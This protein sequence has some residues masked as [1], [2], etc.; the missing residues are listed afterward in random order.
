MYSDKPFR[1]IPF[2]TLYS[3]T[4]L[5]VDA[6]CAFLLLGMLNLGDH[7]ITSMLLYNGFAFV[8]QA[9]FGFIIDKA[10]NPKAAAMLGLAFVAVSF[11]F[12]N[13]IFA[14]LTIAGIGNALFHVAGGSLVLTLKNKIATFSG[15]Y[16]APGGIGLALGSFLS[17]SQ[18]NINFMLFPLALIILGLMLCYVKTPEFNRT[19]EKENT[20]DYR[21]V[22][23]GLIMI[24]IVVRSMIGL[25]I[26]FP[27][28]E[29]HFL[30]LLLIAA[31]AL[32]KVFGG[33][34]AERYGLIKVGV[35]GLLV[36]SPLLAFFSSMPVLGILGAFILNF[37]MPVTLMAIFN[38]L[39][40]NKGLVFGLTTVA[41]FIGALP[42]IIGN[43]L[44]LKQYWV[45][46]LLI[47][48]AAMILFA[49][50]CFKPV[51]Y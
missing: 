25:S 11:L 47:S 7:I 2:I 27:W 50:L 41:L 35:G 43:D 51:N 13:N 16:V 23:V 18:T 21:I 9:P 3:L 28:K 36:S 26:E 29:N 32:G 1:I 38:V 48:S 20:P 34:L 14:A 37:A 40:Q 8:L 22:I 10:L 39:P 19:N 49:G 24:P 44:W 15:I 4:N 12:W 42:T 17:V 5:T 45:I 46:L 30:F 33:I 31:I 6:A